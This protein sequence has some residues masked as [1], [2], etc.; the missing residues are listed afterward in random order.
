[1]VGEHEVQLAALHRRG[2][3]RWAGQYVRREAVQ[4]REVFVSF[5]YPDLAVIA[6]PRLPAATV[7]RVRQTL[8]GMRSDPAAPG[9]RSCSTRSSSATSPWPSRRCASSTRT[10]CGGA[11]R[12]TSLLDDDALSS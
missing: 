11:S 8:L 1:V 9:R 4:F 7:E 12:S 3:A 10:W 2:I 6:H 5:G